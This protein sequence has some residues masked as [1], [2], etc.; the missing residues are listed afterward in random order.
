MPLVELCPTPWTDPVTV[1]H[2]RA[3]YAE[4]GQVPILV[5]REIEGFVLNRL[6]GVL[7]A[8]AFRLVREGLVSPEDCDRTVKDGLG[9]AGRSSAPSRRS[10]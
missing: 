9:C 4:V 7:L 1:E 3:I 6:Q 2:A 10:N 5:K 8:E